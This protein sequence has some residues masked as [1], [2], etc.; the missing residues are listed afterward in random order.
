MT[1]E[2][3]RLQDPVKYEGSRV[4]VIADNSK[5]PIAHIGDVVFS[6]EDI[7]KELMLPGV[8]H[9]P[10]MK[11]NLLFVTQLASAGHY[12]VFG[13]N[14][15]KVYDKFETKSIPVLNGHRSESIYVMSAETAYVEKTKKNQ[16]SL[17]WHMRL[18]HVSYDKLD[19]MMK[20]KLVAGLPQLEVSKE[21]V[22]VGC[23]YGKAH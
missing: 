19:L 6:P 21:I 20:K 14:D 18:S 13:P 16:T 1:G 7:K 2:K 3:K 9:V 4:V 10:G 15:V 23:Q 8:Y 11:K 17:L 22:C 12:V 5:L